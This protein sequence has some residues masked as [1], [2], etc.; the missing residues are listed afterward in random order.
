MTRLRES[1]PGS[2]TPSMRQTTAPFAGMP[3]PGGND[4]A[5]P[6]VTPV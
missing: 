1:L 6:S 5:G 3:C 4:L 2:L